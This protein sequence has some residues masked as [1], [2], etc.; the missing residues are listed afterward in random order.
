MAKPAQSLQEVLAENAILKRKVDELL[1]ENRV[2]ERKADLG[3]IQIKGLSAGKVVAVEEWAARLAHD[4]KAPFSIF[5]M[6]MDSLRE[7]CPAGPDTDLLF[8]EIKGAIDR[9]RTIMLAVGSP[10][11][12]VAGGK[13]DRKG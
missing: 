9:L 12:E 5:C 8:Q 10:L 3:A 2:L 1:A 6:A 4:V 11:D 13:D 7:R